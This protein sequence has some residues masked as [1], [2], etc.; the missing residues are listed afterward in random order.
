[1]TP[2]SFGRTGRR[3]MG[4][5]W[6][7]DRDPS[8]FAP[9]TG[10]TQN[11]SRATLIAAGIGALATVV[12]AIIAAVAAS[13]DDP[14]PVSTALPQVTSSPIRATPSSAVQSPTDAGP[15]RF[16]GVVQL[17]SS[18]LDLDHIPPSPSW[19]E[20]RYDAAPGKGLSVGPAASSAPWTGAS[21]PDRGQCAQALASN[22][23]E[24][25]HVFGVPQAGTG[26]CLRTN[27]GR[28]AFLRVRQVIEDV[29]LLDAMIWE[30]RG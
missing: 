10:D 15:V 29:T 12:G 7:E 20:L 30:Q 16:Q 4:N 26:F 3:Q 27:V 6:K 21:S 5:F 24:P 2:S 1:M 14:S 8:N 11:T 28:V 18:G 9:M 23:H 13:D 19:E 25:G 17:T 22:P